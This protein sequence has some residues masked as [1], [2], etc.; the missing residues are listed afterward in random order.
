[1]PDKKCATKTAKIATKRDYSDWQ[2][3]SAVSRDAKT[4]LR[5]VSNL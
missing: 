3:I 5:H 2:N 1:M 4:F